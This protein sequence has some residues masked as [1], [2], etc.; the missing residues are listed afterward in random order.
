MVYSCR[1]VTPPRINRKNEF[2]IKFNKYTKD[3]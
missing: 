1:D 2:Q 3:I